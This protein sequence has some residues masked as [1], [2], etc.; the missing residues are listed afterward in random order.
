M[1]CDII[2]GLFYGDESK[3][4]VAYNL[5]KEGH[6]THCMRFNGG[7]NAGHTIYHNGKKYVTHHIP[8]GIFFDIKSIIGPGCVISPDV[9]DS[10]LWQLTWDF[11]ATKNLVKLANSA[12]II[13]KEQL[14]EDKKDTKIGTTRQGIGPC[15]R[16]KC[17]R[18]GVRVENWPKYDYMKIDVY[19]ELYENKKKVNLL[20]EGAQGF[21]LDI[22]HG[23]YPYVTSSSCSVA[24]A[25]QNGIPY[26]SIRK[27]YG[28][29]K[30]YNTY[31]GAKQFQPKGE[32]FE[33]L[34]DEGKEIGATTGRKRQCNWN[35]L[36]LLKKAILMNGVTD[37]IVNKMDIVK[38]I[39][40]WAIYDLDGSLKEFNKE[41]DFIDCIQNYVK[42]WGVKEVKFSYSK[43]EI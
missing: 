7:C 9:L 3:G 27:V 41:E 16:D 30:S 39:G 4:K 37:L 2:I 42:S 17:D 19:K 1:K 20:L 40:S 8:A 18:K 24:G 33:K 23:D 36:R 5:L 13:T 32:I 22:D 43:E 10:E 38:N 25:L 35:D 11:P 31:V 21:F 28:V 12:H 6:Y 34:Q 15:Y 14:E 26:H 29:M